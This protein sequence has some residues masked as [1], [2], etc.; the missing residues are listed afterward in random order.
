MNVTIDRKRARAG[1]DHKRRDELERMV[2]L[3]RKWRSRGGPFPGVVQADDAARAEIDGSGTCIRRREVLRKVTSM[4]SGEPKTSASIRKGDDSRRLRRIC[5]EL[6]PARGEDDVTVSRRWTRSP[7]A[8]AT[9][10]SRS[11]RKSR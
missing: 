2:S 8:S 4:E 1:R 5:G 6:S 10:T 7:G 9:S 3:T 11:S